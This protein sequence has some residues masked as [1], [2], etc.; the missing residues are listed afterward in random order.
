MEKIVRKEDTYKSVKVKKD[1]V[2]YI[3]TD[4]REFKGK[5]AEKE[6]KQWEEILESQKKFNSIKKTAYEHGLYRIPSEWFC[7][8]T[9]EELE[10][11]KNYIRFYDKYDDVFVNDVRKGRNSGTL[12]I[13]EWIGSDYEDGGDSRGEVK[14]Y[15]LDYI[16]LKIEKFEDI[17]PSKK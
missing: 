16:L 11:V 2:V 17:F 1:V 13:G 9:E 15:T 14:I 8:S 10:I 12:K 6:C 4:G 7:P 5:V 3:A